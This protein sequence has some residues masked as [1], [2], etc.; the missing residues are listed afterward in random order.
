MIDSGTT[1]THKIDL[2]TFVQDET[3]KYCII[4]TSIH[5]YLAIEYINMLLDENDTAV[6]ITDFIASLPDND[7][8]NLVLAAAMQ[9]AII[10][11]SFLTGIETFPLN[12]EELFDESRRQITTAA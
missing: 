7:F 1:Y 4:N 5:I 11:D 6:T 3:V 8:I 9:D 12:I 2:N 10:V